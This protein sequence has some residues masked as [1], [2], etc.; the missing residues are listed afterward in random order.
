MT[1][2]AQTFQSLYFCNVSL[3]SE[4][5][6]TAAFCLKEIVSRDLLVQVAYYIAFYK[7]MRVFNIISPV[8]FLLFSINQRHK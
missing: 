4:N 7:S 6:F 8:Y 1:L 3:D 2:K 5:N